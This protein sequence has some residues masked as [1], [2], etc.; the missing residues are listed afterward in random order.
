MAEQ[1]AFLFEPAQQLE[2]VKGFGWCRPPRQIRWRL[3]W[4]NGHGTSSCF[5]K[6]P[7]FGSHEP[8]DA[9]SAAQTGATA[10]PTA[11]SVLWPDTVDWSTWRVTSIPRP[12]HIGPAIC[13]RSIDRSRLDADDRPRMARDARIAAIGIEVEQGMQRVGAATFRRKAEKIQR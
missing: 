13:S 3:P 11:T 4:V 7:R 8:V 6:Q 12:K 9:G 10:A 1:A 5:C 2:E